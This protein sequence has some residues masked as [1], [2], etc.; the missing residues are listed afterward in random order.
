MEKIYQK[1]PEIIQLLQ[2]NMKVIMTIAE[3][4]N[5]DIDYNA[6]GEEIDN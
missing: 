2:N 6:F 5:F 4:T 1:I 3:T